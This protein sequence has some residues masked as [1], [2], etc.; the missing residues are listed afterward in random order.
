MLKSED[1]PVVYALVAVALALFVNFAALPPSTSDMYQQDPGNQSSNGAQ[2]R[3]PPYE[4][5]TF[6]VFMGFIATC[7]IATYGIRQFEESR[8]SS[9]RELRAYLSVVIGGGFFKINQVGLSSMPAR[10]FG[11]MG[12]H[13]PIMSDI[14]FERV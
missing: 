8:R 12:L 5:E 11:I 14:K 9:E 13:L 10:R 7:V 1:R 6:W 2:E 3:I 4:T